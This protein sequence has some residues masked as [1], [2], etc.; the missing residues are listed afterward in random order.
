MIL[1][2]LITNASLFHMYIVQCTGTLT[3]VELHTL[4]TVVETKQALIEC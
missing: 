4:T 1:S 3:Q 2:I